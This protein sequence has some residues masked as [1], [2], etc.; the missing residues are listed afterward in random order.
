MFKK[1]VK[2]K[3]RSQNHTTPEYLYEIAPVKY[4][5]EEST[6]NQSKDALNCDSQQEGH[7][8]SKA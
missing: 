6:L 5:T 2:N 7:I 3:N 4:K 8:F 1:L